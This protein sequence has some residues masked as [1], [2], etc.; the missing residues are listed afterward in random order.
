MKVAFLS[1]VNKSWSRKLL[2]HL[3]RSLSERSENSRFTRCSHSSFVKFILP[4]SFHVNSNKALLA[5]N[6][7]TVPV[8]ES[9]ETLRVL[10]LCH[11]RATKAQSRDLAPP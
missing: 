8:C 6:V 9:K 4:S 10:L 5:L 3:E 2:T 7:Q 11:S 1:E